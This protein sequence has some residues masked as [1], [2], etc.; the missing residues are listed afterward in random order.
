MFKVLGLTFSVAR[1][2]K[3]SCLNIYLVKQMK[4]LDYFKPIQ[5]LS[6]NTWKNLEAEGRQ[7]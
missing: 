5:L 3:P 7:A 4:H 1:K 2:K 6:T